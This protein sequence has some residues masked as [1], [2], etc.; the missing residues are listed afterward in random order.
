V[1]LI[2]SLLQY[3]SLRFDSVP[4]PGD[5]SG[6]PFDRFQEESGRREVFVVDIE[7]SSSADSTVRYGHDE[8]ADFVNQPVA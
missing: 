6:S 7:K 3:S 1:R 4:N 8:K 5:I 2:A